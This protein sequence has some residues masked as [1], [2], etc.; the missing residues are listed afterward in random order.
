MNDERLVHA[1][2]PLGGHRLAADD[3]DAGVVG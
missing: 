1:L 2:L 3:L